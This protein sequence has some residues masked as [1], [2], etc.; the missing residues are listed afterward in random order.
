VNRNVI[1]VLCI[2]VGITGLLLLGKRASKPPLTA[3]TGSPAPSSGDPPTGSMAPDFT[4][5]SVPDGKSIQLSALRGKAVLVNFWATWCEP[6]KTEM[7]WLENLHKKYSSQG[8]EIL[9]IAMDDTE[10]E[11][12]IAAFAKKMGISYT[13]LKGT[14]KV[15]DLYGGIDRLPLSYFIDRSG[16]VVQEIVGR[17]MEESAI[18]DA[19]KQSL[20]SGK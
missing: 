3:G 10:N 6:C 14:D 11:K 8:L 2:V 12:P 16:K 13:I 7:P 9:G 1:V 20:D 17:P 19:I 5:R 18:E 4:L 15:G